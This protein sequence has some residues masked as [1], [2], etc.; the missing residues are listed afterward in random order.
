MAEEN[1]S[2]GS[3][4]KDLLKQRSLSMKKLSEL[5]EIDTATVSRIIN[6]KRKAN[7]RHLQKIAECLDIPIT[8][9]FVAASYLTEPQQRKLESSNDIHSSI[10]T[11]QNII[12]FSNLLSKKFTI[13]DVKHHLAHYQQYSK[14]EEGRETILA[15]FEEKLQKVGSIGPFIDHLKEMFDKFRLRKGTPYQL[16]VIGG[17]L[18]YFI[19]PDDVIPDYIF[20][21]G[22]L[23]D[24]IAV[25]LTLNLLSKRLC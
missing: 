3:L 14:T 13:E 2:I 17:A 16:A 10:E 5:T 22:Y 1:R 18:L 21:I 24:A 12:E 7:P 19:L 23:D 15:N 4:L 11:I 8:D 20:P 9:L 6:G 25:Q